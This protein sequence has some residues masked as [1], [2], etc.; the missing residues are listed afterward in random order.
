[1]KGPEFWQELFFENRRMAIA[2]KETVKPIIEAHGLTPFQAHL[3][4]VLK[5]EDGQSISRL[6]SQACM[7][8]SNFTPLWHS[9]EEQGYVERRRDEADRRS[10]RLFITEKGLAKTL[11]V[12]GAISRAFTDSDD[13]ELIAVL[14]QQILDG[15]AAFRRLTELTAITSLSPDPREEE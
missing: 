14:Q 1:M 13:P 6:S 3:L 8:P 15:F 7:K 12:E 2:L 11:L 5:I 10:W 4:G 9:L